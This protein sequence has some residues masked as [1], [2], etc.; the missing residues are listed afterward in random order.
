MSPRG[1]VWVDLNAADAVH[2]SHAIV[3]QREHKIVLT[4]VVTRPATVLTYSEIPV[5]PSEKC[6]CQVPTGGRQEESPPENAA[7][8]ISQKATIL[9]YAFP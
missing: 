1:S 4:P 5:G 9:V 3:K 6:V 2:R 8:P 7:R